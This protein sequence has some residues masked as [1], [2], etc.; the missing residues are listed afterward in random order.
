MPPDQFGSVTLPLESVHQLPDV[1]C[2]LLP[3]FLCP[4]PIHSIGSVLANVSPALPEHPLVEH[5]IEVAKPI[6]LLAFGLLRYPL[7]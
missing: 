5:P 6:P 2:E 3:I 1:L 4:Y 7:Q